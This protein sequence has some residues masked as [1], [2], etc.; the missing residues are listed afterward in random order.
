MATQEPEQDNALSKVARSVGSALG[1]VASKVNDLVGD[2]PE[3]D[4]KS[5]SKASDDADKKDEKP[6]SKS[7]K[8]ADTDKSSEKSESKPAKT[9][10][11]SATAK[12]SPAKKSAADT[13]TKSKSRA[14]QVKKLKRDKHRR[15]L[16]RKTR[17]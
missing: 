9:G 13:A 2:K 5:D 12:A 7:T 14:Q 3:A 15:K 4:D 6:E 16:G 8:S 1:T 17:G 10:G 11:A